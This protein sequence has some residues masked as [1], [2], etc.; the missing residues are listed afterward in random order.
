MRQ[1]LPLAKDQGV[2]LT[3]RMNEYL[4]N[5]QKA[6]EKKVNEVLSSE[7][8]L[9]FKSRGM[10]RG[11]F[12]VITADGTLVVECNKEIA[13]CDKEIAEHIIVLHNKQKEK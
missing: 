6:H 3:L 2:S 9:G 7:W 10:G 4:E 8:K 11:D 1:F 5:L 12:S 13:G